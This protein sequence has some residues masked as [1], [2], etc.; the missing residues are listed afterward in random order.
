MSNRYSTT[1]IQKDNNNKYHYSTLVYPNIEQEIN[2]TYIITKETDRLDILS[3]KYYGDS[4]LYWI[5]NLVNNIN[6][7]SIFIKPG[8]QLCIPNKSRINSIITQMKNL[9]L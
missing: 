2:D 8:I 3:Y 7:S 4:E 9:N 5:I 6:N 1:K